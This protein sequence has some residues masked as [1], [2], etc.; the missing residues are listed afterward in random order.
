M[1][2]INLAVSASPSGEEINGPHNY[3]RTRVPKWKESG[4]PQMRTNRMGYL[5]HA[6]LGS[7]GG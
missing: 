6:V 2:F 5:S 3:C 4:G 7:Q 1:C